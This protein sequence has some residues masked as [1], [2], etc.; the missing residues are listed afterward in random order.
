MSETTPS[1]A[2]GERD[3]IGE[4]A[5]GPASD[6]QPEPPRTTPSQAEGDDDQSEDETDDNADGTDGTDG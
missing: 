3:A 6:R 1:Q 2:E 5:N 4:E